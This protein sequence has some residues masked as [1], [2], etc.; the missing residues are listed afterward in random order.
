M[1]D[2]SRNGRAKVTQK[3]LPNASARWGVERSRGIN[4]VA[5]HFFAGRWLFLFGL[6]KFLDDRIILDLQENVPGTNVCAE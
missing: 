1:L 4:G 5:L 6:D 2:V 3:R